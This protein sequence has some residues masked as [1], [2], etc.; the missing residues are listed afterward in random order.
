[1]PEDLGVRV[2]LAYDNMTVGRVIFPPGMLRQQLLRTHRVE[3]V[4]P[5]PEYLDEQIK[6]PVNRMM[7]AVKRNSETLR[8]QAAPGR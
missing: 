5:E 1:M 2:I 7:R 4:T 6:S 3:V 8:A